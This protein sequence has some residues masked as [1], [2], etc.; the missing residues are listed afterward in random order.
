MIRQA[1]IESPAQQLP[2]TDILDW[3]EINFS[4]FR[5][6]TLSLAWEVSY[7]FL[8]YSTKM[9][10]NTHLFCFSLR[11]QSAVRNTLSGQKCFTR[12]K[13]GSVGMWKVVDEEYF[14]NR[15]FKQQ[16]TTKKA[17]IK[18]EISQPHVSSTSQMAAAAA[19]AS[20]EKPAT[21][22]INNWT[23][24]FTIVSSTSTNVNAQTSSGSP[25][26][27]GNPS[28]SLGSRVPTSNMNAKRK[29]LFKEKDINEKRSRSDS[30]SSNPK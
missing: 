8:N 11:F 5:N 29:M 22:R 21:K 19:A 10:V 3:F 6:N 28:T 9:M 26:A 15:T 7:V 24:S 20:I 1:I 18:S 2:T 13:T 14:K 25:K 27:V 17:L 16:I 30:S 12:V 4:Y 23:S